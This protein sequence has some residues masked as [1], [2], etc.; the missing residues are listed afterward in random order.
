MT[1]EFTTQENVGPHVN[2]PLLLSDFNQNWNALTDFRN[3]NLFI[4]KYSETSLKYED[5]CLLGCAM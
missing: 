4:L 2:C 3:Y 5:G 1:R